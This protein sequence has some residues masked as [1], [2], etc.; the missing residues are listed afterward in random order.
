MVRM[1]AMSDVHLEFAGLTLNVSCWP[2]LVVLEGDI[3]EATREW[4]ESRLA[5]SHDGPT[6]VITHHSPC[7]RSTALG[8]LAA[9]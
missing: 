8:T 9:N 5:H 1:L 2:D 4:L 7:A 3:Y 6:I